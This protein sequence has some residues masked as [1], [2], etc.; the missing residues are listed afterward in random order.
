MPAAH[1][2]SNKLLRFSV[3]LLF[4]EGQT[5][6]FQSHSFSSLVDS[7]QTFP[8]IDRCTSQSIV[9]KLSRLVPF[10]SLAASSC[11]SRI[12]NVGSLVS[13]FPQWSFIQFERNVASN[14][15]SLPGGAAWA[16]H[17]DSRDTPGSF[18]RADAFCPSRSLDYWKRVCKTLRCQE[19]LGSYVVYKQSLSETIGKSLSCNLFAQGGIME[20]FS[21]FFTSCTTGAASDMSL[22]Q[23]LREEQLDDPSSESDQKKPSDRALKLL[24]GSCYLPHP[25][26]EETGGEDAHFIW[27]EQAIGVADG[28]GGWADHGVDAGQYSRS[29]MSHSVDAIEEESKGSIDP[30]RV[31]EKAYT[32]TKAEGSSTACIVALTDQGIHA[33]N[34]GDSGFIVVRDGCTIFRS[35]VQQHD[36]NFTYQLESNNASDL[37]SAA[38]VFS[39][40]VESGDVIVAGTD[41]LF[42]NLYN[43]EIT[44]VVVH[45]IRAGLGPQVMAQK[46]AA[47]ARQRA[48]DKNRQTPFS[49]AAQEA[50]FRYYGGKL[51]DITVIVSYITAFGNQAP[52]CL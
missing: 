35:P 32:R 37:P 20:L 41:G 1:I 9:G 26:K 16:I 28:V 38:Q 42:D 48:Q 10:P 47:L 29:L 46:I 34:L 19:A 14:C 6:L 52:S 49:A 7:I 27:D 8:I 25:D 45:G 5:G 50:G 36:F 3:E 39:F 22:D 15:T 12:H 21:L 23:S 4:R 40:P 31:L 51:D 43:S 33:V 30:L 18:L 24:S 44:A 13:V 2:S 17:H 11:Q